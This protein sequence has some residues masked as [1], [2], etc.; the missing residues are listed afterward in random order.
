MKQND[1]IASISIWTWIIYKFYALL[2][3]EMQH[4]L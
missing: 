1:T 3:L 2:Y 4:N